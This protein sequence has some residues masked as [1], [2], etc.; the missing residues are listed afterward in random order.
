M[1]RATGGWIL[2]A[3][4]ILTCPAHAQ[5]APRGALEPDAVLADINARG[6]RAVLSR[7]STNEALFDGIETG[8]PKWLEVARQLRAVSD[9]SV[10]LSLDYAVAR[11]LPHAPDQVLLLVGRGFTIDSVCTCPFVEPEPGVVEDY[12]R[13]AEAALRRVTAPGLTQLRDQCLARV[14]FRP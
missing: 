3:S 12:A 14:H 11:A 6:A 8:H 5:P 4:L 9:A 1:L 7:A 13:R 2:L 10:A